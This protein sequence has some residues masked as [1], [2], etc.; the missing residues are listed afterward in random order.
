[1][2]ERV[3]AQL[4]EYG[5]TRRGWLGVRIQNVDE[6]MAE[7]LGLEGPEGALITD[8]P[9]GPAAKAGMKSGDVIISFDGEPIEDTR[10]LVRIVAET[11]I[12]RTVDVEVI[13]DG[14]AQTLA[15]EIGLLEEPT[16][17]AAA[18]PESEQEQ[19]SEETVLGLT[20]TALTDAQREELGLDAEV[21]GLVVSGVAE[22]SD[23]FDKGLREGDVI[24]EVGQEPVASAREMRERIRAA[25]EAG[26]NSILLL[27]RRD[28]APRFVALN[29][30][31]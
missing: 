7:A 8:V 24:V 6:D 15:V 28:D 4:Q 18:G 12:G 30:S 27:V 10:E 17:A 31:N 25:E 26:R 21:T 23:A 22:D 16:L 2:V 1:V 9:E 13:R 29:L 20:V 19:P 5:E 11:E 3:V 14:E